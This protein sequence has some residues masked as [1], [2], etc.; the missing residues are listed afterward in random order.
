[1]SAETT[2]A[3]AG[4]LRF[5][6]LAVE[7]AEA[8]LA[9]CLAVPRW[10]S[11]LVAGRPY[12]KAADVLTL[13]RLSASRMSESE[14]D[15]ALARHPRIGERAR[16]GHDVEFSRREQ[17]SVEGAGSGARNAIELGNA[18]YE[19]RFG[20]VFLIRASGRSATEILDELNRR[21]GNDEVTE[22]AEVIGQLGEI[23]VGRLEQLLTGLPG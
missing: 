6:A 16:A 8:E 10:V 22:T 11:E 19:E 5:N 4:V 14:L 7:A 18:A 2:A 9:T 17:A 21:T 23:A 20:R 12:R 15:E 1:M 3:E 13:A